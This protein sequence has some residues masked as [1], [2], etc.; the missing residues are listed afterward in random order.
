MK[1]GEQEIKCSPAL[2]KPGTKCGAITDDGEPCDHPAVM[3]CDDGSWCSCSICIT[4][5]GAS[6]EEWMVLG[7]PESPGCDGDC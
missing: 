5:C 4:I 7:K 2:A 3:T 6:L 1:T